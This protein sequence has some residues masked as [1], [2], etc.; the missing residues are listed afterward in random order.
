[1]PRY[2]VSLWTE[3]GRIL[4]R[5][6]D[7]P[8]EKALREGLSREGYYVFEV[9]RGVSLLASLR[10]PF[11][12]RGVGTKEL[13]SFN[14]EL[15]ALTKAGLP[16]IRSLDTIMERTSEPR[17]LAVLKDVRE[18]VKGGASLSEA[19]ER[20]PRAFPPLYVATIRA[21]EKS[22][23]VVFSLKRYIEYL[24]KMEAVRKKIVS[25]SIYPAI[26]VFVAI[27]VILF[28]L[29]YVVPTFSRIYL[30]A[31]SRLPYPTQVL[32]SITTFLRNYFLMLLLLLLGAIASLSLHFRTEEGRRRLD[33]LKLKL[34]FI[35]SILTGYAVSKFARTLSTVLGGGIPLV[36]SVRMV[37]G[38]MGN[39][40]LEG[41]AFSV[42]R[43]VE[44]GSTLTDAVEAEDL[45][46]SLAVKMLGVGEGTGGLEEMLLDIAAYYEEEVDSRLSALTTVIEPALM[47][48]MGV[49]VAAIVIAM[50]L[51]VFKLAETAP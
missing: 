46:P 20:F 51:P 47:L 7:S 18:A 37:A 26:L 40:V 13:I 14:Q 43:R 27:G 38:V 50:Y 5:E 4:E 22:G 2:I 30:E 33:N 44:E 41:K 17:F 15:L 28:L 25:A 36:D 21:G 10:E 49:F 42:V 12:V 45:M 6:Y 19:F 23:D 29:S 34:P 11:S 48:V 8:D 24:K 16:I 9:K 31:G 39:K 1:M 3:D 32:I 35:G